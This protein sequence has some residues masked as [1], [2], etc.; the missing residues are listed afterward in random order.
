MSDYNIHNLIRIH[1]NV[2]LH[3]L[4]FFET[5]EKPEQPDLDIS[6]GDFTPNLD[7][8]VKLVKSWVGNDSLYC[9]DHHKFCFYKVWFQ[10]IDAKTTKIN[11]DGDPIFS[12]IIFYVLF[13]EPFLTYKML[14][15]NILFLHSSSIS[16]N[17]KGVLFSGMTGTGKTTALLRLLKFDNT[18]FSDDQSIIFKDTLYSYPMQIGL[19]MHLVLDSGVQLDMWN[20]SMVILQSF[21]NAIT[22][23][24]GNLTQRV[25]PEKMKFNGK[26]IVSGNSCKLKYVFLLT[27]GNESSVKKITSDEGYELLR[28]NNQ[29]NEDKQKIIFRFFSRYKVIYPNFDY[30]DT[31]PK[32]LGDF[33][34]TPGINFYKVTM[35]EKYSIRDSIPEIVK[36]IDGV[37]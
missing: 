35:P 13:L 4:K 32:Q 25:E 21:I 36:I 15:K 29:Q 2:P 31:F 6:I 7:S 27:L 5:K 30:W 23:S 10:G 33:A 37:G 8:C 3:R 19:K 11:F 17:G 28:I 22:F 16:H 9:K 20:Y 24:Y 34:K 1:S 18:Y 12:N 26:S 14:R